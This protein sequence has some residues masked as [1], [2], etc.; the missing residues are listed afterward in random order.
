M[1]QFYGYGQQLMT[2]AEILGASDAE[3]RALARSQASLRDS[4]D[5]AR[6]RA[7][8]MAAATA[9]SPIGIG[10]P[11]S[12]EIAY[13]YT[14]VLSKKGWN[15][16]DLMLASSVKRLPLYDAAPRAIQALLRSLPEN[17]GFASL[18]ATEPGT[19]LV[20]HTPSLTDRGVTVTIEMVFDRFPSETFDQVGNMLATAGGI[21]VF[22]PA[23]AYLMAGSLIVKLFA[24]VAE[25]IVDGRPT[26]SQ[27]L[28]INVERPL[29]EDTS[30]GLLLLAPAGRLA[31][32][33]ARKEY[34]IDVE[35]GLL[36]AQGQLQGQPY[37]GPDPYVVV[38]LDGTPRPDYAGFA[39]TLAAASILDRFLHTGE[40]RPTTTGL[41]VDALK[42]Y[43][44]VQYRMMADSAKKRLDALEDQN[45]EE[46]AHLKKL[47]DAYVK[48]IGNEDLRPK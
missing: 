3:L 13:V 31:D 43:N 40:G 9:A 7:F 2:E 42:A 15:R 12:V 14:G 18:P 47:L 24:K 20:Y 36:H 39:P 28:N 17:H 5:V 30:P 6:S 34:Q 23:S 27:N 33:L 22:A 19:P 10:R 29:Y 11:L 8:G 46:G 4:L 37:A 25:A 44:D 35:R 1:P 32:G 48:N 45:G 26:F 16:P 38:S 21:P 41:V